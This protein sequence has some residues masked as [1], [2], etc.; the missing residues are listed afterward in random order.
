MFETPIRLKLS[1]KMEKIDYLLI[2]EGKSRKCSNN[3]K[4]AS[5]VITFQYMQDNLLMGSLLNL[6]PV[7]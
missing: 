6:K 2:Y 5:S 7:C 4:N 3:F 1:G